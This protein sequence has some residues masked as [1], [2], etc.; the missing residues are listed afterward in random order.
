MTARSA[1]RTAEVAEQIGVHPK[2]VAKW[3]TSGELTSVRIG[4]CV[5][6]LPD[7]LAAFLA[8]H[9]EGRGVAPRSRTPRQHLKTA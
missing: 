4:G 6:V 9:R 8:A 2:T 3:I 1:L 5:R 7:D